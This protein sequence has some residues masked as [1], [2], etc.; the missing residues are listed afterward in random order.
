MTQFYKLLG[1]ELQNWIFKKIISG[2]FPPTP[3]CLPHPILQTTG[4]QKGKR[5]SWHASWSSSCFLAASYGKEKQ[6]GRSV[7]DFVES[8]ELNLGS[9]ESWKLNGRVSLTSENQAT[10]GHPWPS[11]SLRNLRVKQEAGSLARNKDL[12][13]RGMNNFI[14]FHQVTQR[15]ALGAGLEDIN[16]HKG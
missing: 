2:K 9:S 4:E 7:H 8:Q 3:K 6:K 12:D 5:E 10:C 13:I 14:G 1:T 15:Q 16:Q 11:W